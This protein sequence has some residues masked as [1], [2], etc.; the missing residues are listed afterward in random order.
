MM[1]LDACSNGQSEENALKVL[2][3]QLKK[4]FRGGLMKNVA[5]VNCNSRCD[6]KLTAI[7]ENVKRGLSSNTNRLNEKVNKAPPSRMPNSCQLQSMVHDGAVYGH[8]QG[9]MGLSQFCAYGQAPWFPMASYGMQHDNTSHFM[10][11]SMQQHGKSLNQ[12]NASIT[13]SQPQQE[14]KN[15]HQCN[16]GFDDPD[17][18]SALAE[19]ET[20]ESEEVTM[21]L[22]AD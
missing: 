18:S 19:V 7:A 21:I 4:V 14:T 2:S 3:D 15:G 11:P 8:P 9:M 6:S 20:V 13:E 16:A 1:A 17:F 5:P 12:H 22:L 10:H